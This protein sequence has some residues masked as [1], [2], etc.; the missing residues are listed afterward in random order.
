MADD[1]TTLEEGGPCSNLVAGQSLGPQRLTE[2]SQRA[3][4]D[5]EGQIDLPTATAQ[6]LARGLSNADLEMIAANLLENGSSRENLSDDLNVVRTAFKTVR[7]Q[8]MELSKAAFGL[9]RLAV[10]GTSVQLLGSTPTVLPQIDA[11]EVSKYQKELNA[12]IRI[13]NLNTWWPAHLAGKAG[14]ASQGKE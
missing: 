6:M 5:T 3:P 1:S 4:R 8:L 7:H 14:G 12:R 9:S 11:P 13:T 2:L 10:Q